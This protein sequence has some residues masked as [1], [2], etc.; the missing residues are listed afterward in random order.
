MPLIH[1]KN[2]IHIFKK[3]DKKSAFLVKISMGFGAARDSSVFLGKSYLF[4][5]VQIYSPKQ[6]APWVCKIHHVVAGNAYLLSGGD[7]VPALK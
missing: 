1:T 6:T 4:L 3:E 7:E 5:F 2:Y